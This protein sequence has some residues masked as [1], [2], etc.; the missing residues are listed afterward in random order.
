MGEV[1]A[2][3]EAVLFA[4][5]GVVAPHR[6]LPRRLP[7][8]GVHLPLSRSAFDHGVEFPFEHLAACYVHLSSLPVMAH[9]I[10]LPRGP[11]S[12]GVVGSVGR[13]RAISG[14]LAAIRHAISVAAAIRPAV[15]L[16]GVGMSFAFACAEF[17]SA[18]ITAIICGESSEGYLF[19]RF[20]PAAI[21]LD[22]SSHEQGQH[23]LDAPPEPAS[24][25]RP[26]LVPLYIY[27]E[28]RSHDFELAVHLGRGG[29]VF[30]L[31]L[32]ELDDRLGHRR[33]VEGG[34]VLYPDH[35]I[36][37][38]EEH[39]RSPAHNLVDGSSVLSPVGKPRPPRQFDGRLEGYHLAENV[40]ES[41][42]QAG[43]LRVETLP[44]RFL[45]LSF[46]LRP[47]CARA[48]P[49]GSGREHRYAQ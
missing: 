46:C 31:V 7:F 25:F 29:G 26:R 27:A 1:A 37:V 48:P 20:V 9:G 6:L 15:I 41:A 24:R 11:K 21:D 10:V 42:E 2:P 13:S 35:L 45:C 16:S 43:M 19:G 32:H 38:F 14:I 3:R 22:T 49:L 30:H 33:A 44:N 36:P 39:L 4:S 34:L 5:A 40:K 12:V 18:A 28:L 8:G 47:E 17:S 23:F